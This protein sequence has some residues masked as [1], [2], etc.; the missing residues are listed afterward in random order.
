MLD[1]DGVLNR[2]TEPY[3][4]TGD[5]RDDVSRSL[6]RRVA[7]ILDQVPEAA[8]VVSSMWRVHYRLIE[9]R[10]ILLPEI[11]GRRVI[12]VTPDGRARGREIQAWLRTYGQPVRVAILDDNDDGIFDMTPMRR[13][14][15]RTDEA[16]GVSDANVAA[17]VRLLTRGP[18]FR[19]VV[20]APVRLT[21]SPP[22]H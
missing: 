11:D 1:F 4:W 8:I 21:L 7:T 22:L 5:P 18:V 16:V 13:W 19:P 3:R 2:T 17:A 6:V 14:F 20:P 9:L 15:V 10:R 12:D